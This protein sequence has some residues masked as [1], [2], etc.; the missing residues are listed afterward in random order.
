[1]KKKLTERET[2]LIKA[3]AEDT[4]LAE[5]ARDI[6]DS[7]LMAPLNEKVKLC[8]N[9]SIGQYHSFRT[10]RVPRGLARGILK[11]IEDWSDGDRIFAESE[12]DKL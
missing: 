11:Y 5:R 2:E 6:N 7:I 12:F 8:F 9:F 4:A 3:I 10:I 1:M